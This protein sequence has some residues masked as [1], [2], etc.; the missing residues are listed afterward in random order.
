MKYQCDC[1]KAYNF[2]GGQMSSSGST[3]GQIKVNR[4]QIM[5]F[6]TKCM[7]LAICIT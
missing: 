6:R 1:K 2:L 3:K 4:R 7:I 5:I